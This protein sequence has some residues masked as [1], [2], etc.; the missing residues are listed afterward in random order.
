MEN[1]LVLLKKGKYRI[2]EVL[3]VSRSLY[4]LKHDHKEDEAGAIYKALLQDGESNRVI[5]FVDPIDFGAGSRIFVKEDLASVLV[6][7]SNYVLLDRKRY[8][9]NTALVEK[10]LARRTEREGPRQTYK[11]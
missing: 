6:R 4:G 8:R 2:V 1:S 9:V 5:Y 11:G 7:S 10:L 3:C